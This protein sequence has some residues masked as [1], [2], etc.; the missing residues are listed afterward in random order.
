MI[1]GYLTLDEACANYRNF[2]APFK[3]K[4]GEMAEMIVDGF[5]IAALVVLAGITAVWTFTSDKNVQKSMESW[6]KKILVG[7][8]IMYGIG[9]AAVFA[10]MKS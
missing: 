2:T 9:T 10:W 7:A 4:G 3:R 6:G 8:T 5:G 1:T